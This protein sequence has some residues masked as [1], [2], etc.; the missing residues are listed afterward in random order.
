MNDNSKPLKKKRCLVC[1]KKIK[2]M[3]FS[4]DCGGIFCIEHQSRH[5]HNCDLL[6]KQKQLKQ[7]AVEINNPKISFVK[8]V[9]I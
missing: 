5:S 2:M 8:L 3:S 9:T 6:P 1:N 7:E 4:C